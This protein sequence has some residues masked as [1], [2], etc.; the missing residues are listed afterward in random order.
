MSSNRIMSINCP[1]CGKPLQVL[2]S[3]ND[4][5]V[6]VHCSGDSCTFMT[7][8]EDCELIYLRQ[9]FIANENIREV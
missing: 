7:K 5:K 6:I 8:V 9:Y 3:R 2:F 4:M 1:I